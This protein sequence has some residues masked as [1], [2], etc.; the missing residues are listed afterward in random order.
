M[1]KKW[2]GALLAASFMWLGTGCTTTKQTE[3]AR[4]A[5]EQLL[6]STAADRALAKAD[7]SDFAGQ[8]IFLDNS[9]YE[10]YDSKYVIGA[11]R[12]SLSRAGG[13]LV[14]TAA[15][16]D[17]IVEARSGGLSIDSSDSLLGIP[18]SGLPI[19]L[20][21][22]VQI[23]ELALYKSEKEF[24]IA[25]LALLA[26]TNKTGAHFYS[27]GPLVGKAFD[28]NFKLI[29]MISWV[30]TDVPEEIPEKRHHKKHKE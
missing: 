29:G 30:R 2:I 8:K 24:S 18:A 9:N 27:S 17:L 22:A 15:E 11:I 10:S 5:S 25:K 3:P 6:L 28:K 12:D 1:E 20:A 16:A 13:L 23:P 7:F 19:P 26:Y 14:K 21:G 4:A